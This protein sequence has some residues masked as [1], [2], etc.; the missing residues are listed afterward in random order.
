MSFEI[1]PCFSF[2]RR[3]DDRCAYRI[4]YD[5]YP[6]LFG[7]Y[8]FE[9]RHKPLAA[10][11]ISFIFPFEPM[12]ADPRAALAKSNRNRPTDAASATKND[13]R[14]PVKISAH[15]TCYLSRTFTRAVPSTYTIPFTPVTRVA[16]SKTRVASDL[17]ITV[18]ETSTV[19]PGFNGLRKWRSCD[20]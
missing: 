8:F 11:D 12:R 20:K 7:K 14:F 13:Y 19:A 3:D 2:K 15:D 17:R 9:K 18:P 1:F 16:S 6:R 4:H 5:V 10:A